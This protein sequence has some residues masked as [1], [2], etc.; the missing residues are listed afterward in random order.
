MADPAPLC[1]KTRGGGGVAYKD[2]AR[3][4]SPWSGH[5]IKNTD[6]ERLIFV[7]PEVKSCDVYY[8]YQPM[9]ICEPSLEGSIFLHLS[10]MT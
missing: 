5:K 6:S 9:H 10:Y 1:F 4:P 7:L 3:P 2:R 8:V